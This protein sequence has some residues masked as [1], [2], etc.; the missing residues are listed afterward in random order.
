MC[1]LPLFLQLIHVSEHNIHCVDVLFVLT[2]L[3]GFLSWCVPCIL[4]W[5][6]ILLGLLTKTCIRIKFAAIF[7]ALF[8]IYIY[9]YIHTHTHKCMLTSNT[10][11][12]W[13]VCTLMNWTSWHDISVQYLSEYFVFLLPEGEDVRVDQLCTSSQ[14]NSRDAYLQS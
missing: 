14:K 8:Y 7:M 9:I 13:V 4:L 5:M 12:Q 6:W 3:S 11:L 10:V 1:Y 2:N